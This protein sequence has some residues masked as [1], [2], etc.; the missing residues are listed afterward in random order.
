MNENKFLVSLTILVG[1]MHEKFLTSSNL[2]SNCQKP[3]FN[4]FARTENQHEAQGDIYQFI[5]GSTGMFIAP[6]ETRF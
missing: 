6:G 3:E 4:L 2:G 1:Y 5:G